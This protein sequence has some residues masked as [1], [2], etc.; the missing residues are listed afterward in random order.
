VRQVGLVLREVRSMLVV[1]GLVKGR[2]IATERC[3]FLLEGRSAA[4]QP[5][6]F[7]FLRFGHAPEYSR[8]LFSREFI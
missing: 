3:V 5:N 8:L 2:D 4:H 7:L 6:M 1:I